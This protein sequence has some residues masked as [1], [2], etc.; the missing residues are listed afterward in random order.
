V[1]VEFALFKSDDL[2]QLK[3]VI[4]LKAIK[5]IFFILKI[6]YVFC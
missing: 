2:L 5:I 6:I 1:F 4:A 3:I